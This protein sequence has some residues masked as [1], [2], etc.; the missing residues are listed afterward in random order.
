MHETWNNFYFS[1]IFQDQLETSNGQ[2]GIDIN[3]LMANPDFQQ[4]LQHRV[5]VKNL[6]ISCFLRIFTENN[7]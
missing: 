2:P 6:N 4:W 7:S 3:Q 1:A 5:D